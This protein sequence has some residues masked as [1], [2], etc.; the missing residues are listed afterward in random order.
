VQ[1]FRPIH[2]ASEMR[3]VLPLMV[4]VAAGWC[5]IPSLRPLALNRRA[6]AVQLMSNEGVT[7][8]EDLPADDSL[9][10]ELNQQVELQEFNKGLYDHLNKRPEYE[11]SEIYS[12]LRK[13]QDVDDPLYSELQAR[14]EML[15]NAPLPNEDQTPGEIIELVLRALRDVDWPRPGHGVDVLRNY[16]GPASIL[17][18]DKP[19][20]TQE[21]LIEYFASSKYCI[22]LDWVS[23]QYKRKLELSLDKNRALQ[24]IRLINSSGESV[25][26]TFQLSKHSTERGTVWLIDQLLVKSTD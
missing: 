19:E 8:P 14:R 26:V 10:K 12:A 7:D 17:G 16:S 22:L 20:V 5:P 21:M 23:I 11:T 25:P 18:D 1:P 4:G 13:R 2:N 24:Q 3:V 6:G 9:S 15:S